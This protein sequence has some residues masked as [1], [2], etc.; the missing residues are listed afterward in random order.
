MKKLLLLLLLFA[1][2]AKA[3]TNDFCPV[4]SNCTYTGNNLHTGTETFNNINAVRYISPLNPQGWAGSDVGGWITSASISCTPC[5][6]DVAAGTYNFSTTI[7][8][9]S[10]VTLR[11]AGRSVTVLNWTGSTSGVAMN[12]PVTSGNILVSGLRITNG[13]AAGTTTGI[14]V[15]YGIGLK[16]VDMDVSN[17]QTNFYSTGDGATNQTNGLVIT[18]SF[19]TGSASTYGMY[20]DHTANIV[21]NNIQA[22]SALTSNIVFDSGTNGVFMHLING[23]RG[24]SGMVFKCTGRNGSSSC[25]SGTG[26]YDYPPW[27]IE[28]DQVIMDAVTAS[29]DSFLFDS[30]LG[31]NTLDIKF[32]NIWATAGTNG[33]HISGG[34]KITFSVGTVR[35]SYGNG[36][37]ID[38]ANAGN[39][40]ISNLQITTNNLAN[41][42]DKHGIYITAASPNISILGNRIGNLTEPFGGTGQFYGIKV[43]ASAPN[44]TI[45]GNN[46]N[47]NT[48]GPFNITDTASTL[49][50][51]NLPSGTLVG[52][53]AINL[54]GSGAGNYTGTNTAY[55]N[56]DGTNLCGAVVVPTGWVLAASVSGVLESNT[57]A[58]AQNVALVD[59]GSNCGSGGTTPL[60]GGERI[61]TPPAIGTFDVPFSIQ[62]I[63]TG[64]GA[65]HAIALQAK[66][67]NG[68]DS[69]GIQNSSSTATAQMTLLL[70]PIN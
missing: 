16:F 70:V 65:S 9:N 13:V 25:T 14:K 27:G 29:G 5:E 40:Q 3:Q 66:T 39:I 31:T 68:A 42:A 22:G 49:I 45:Q 2:L 20:F 36:I 38:N 51:N 10:Q 21:L 46:L 61:I 28:G 48:T 58:V 7:Q 12:F 15:I 32:T 56:V 24:N 69:W 57:A 44:L 60:G 67:S 33:I 43:T 63:V 17:F 34:Q 19:F 54:V 59:V 62:A 47:G 30:T 11:G 64:N 6:I 23:F 50:L 26:S 37:L 4:G 1:P 55:A 41:V 53:Q 52:L 8:L 35:G 18:D